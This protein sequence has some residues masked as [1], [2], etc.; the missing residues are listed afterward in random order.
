MDFS[1]DDLDKHL[2]ELLLLDGNDTH[3]LSETG[4]SY[5][6]R[7][8]INLEA[9]RLNIRWCSIQNCACHPEQSVKEILR[10]EEIKSLLTQFSIIGM[11]FTDLYDYLNWLVDN[12]DQS[13]TVTETR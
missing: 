2:F 12:T 8:I 13:I 11:Q 6:N 10:N 5:F 7:L 1:I 3:N 4:K 9:I